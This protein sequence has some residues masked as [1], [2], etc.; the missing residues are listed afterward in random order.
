MTRAAEVARSFAH[1]HADAARVLG[2]WSAPDAGQEQLRR[3]YLS[4]LASHPE[5]VAKAGPPEHLT[6]S[7]LVLDTA[8]ERVLL[9]HH[10]RARQW[11]QFGGHLEVG[12]TSLWAAARRE[13]R[14][15]SGIAGLEPLP[16]PV[17]LD[18]HVLDGDFG[19]CREHL[20][21]RFAAVAPEGAEP[22][23]SEESLDVRWWPVD[24]LP[25]GTRAELSPLV[26]LA[27]RA[28]G[29]L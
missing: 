25:E 28:L 2:A 4:F 9:T 5:G 7:C 1:L 27:R 6:A 20:D 23:T 26:E 3:A 17:Q 12:D 29:L 14:E 8:G 15:E 22:V 18:R 16:D 13:G 19:H 21:V 10:R 24:A 11:F